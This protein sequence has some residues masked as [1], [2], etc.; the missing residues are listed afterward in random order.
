MNGNKKTGKIASK[1]SATGDEGDKDKENESADE[2]GEDG[3]HNKGDQ[4][5]LCVVCKE[6]ECAVM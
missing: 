1:K 5:E 6:S 3:H 4:R 2:E